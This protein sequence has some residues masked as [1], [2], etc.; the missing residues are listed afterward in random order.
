MQLANKIDFRIP[1]YVFKLTWLI[2]NFIVFEEICISE[3][4]ITC[5]YGKY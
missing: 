1:I 3:S 2:R 5:K 4:Q